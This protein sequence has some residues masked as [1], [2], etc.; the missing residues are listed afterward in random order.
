MKKK[1]IN[2][3]SSHALIIVEKLIQL[4]GI[5]IKLVTKLKPFLFNCLKEKKV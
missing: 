2:D 4:F 1:F 5:L 3:F